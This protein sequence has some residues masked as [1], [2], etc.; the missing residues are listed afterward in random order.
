MTEDPRAKPTIPVAP[1]GRVAMLAA[2]ILMSA[3]AVATTQAQLLDQNKVRGMRCEQLA[4]ERSRM[5]LKYKYCID[6]EFY[7]RG[8]NQSRAECNTDYEAFKAT[9]SEED[10]KNWET[11]QRFLRLRRCRF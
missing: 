3:G 2:C 9:L 5:F 10:A 1:A 6:N 4:L 8:L 11:L 7:R